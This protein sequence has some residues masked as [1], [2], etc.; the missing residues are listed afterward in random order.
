LKSKAWDPDSAWEVGTVE[1]Y[2][3]KSHQDDK[4][5]SKPGELRFLSLDEKSMRIAKAR[6][7]A[8]EGQ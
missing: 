3:C 5:E 4:T 2:A 8:R 6:K 1:C 7:K